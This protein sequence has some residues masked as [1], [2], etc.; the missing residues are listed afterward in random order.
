MGHEVTVV[1]SDRYYPFP[2]YQRTVFRL[3]GN[4]HVGAGRQSCDGFLIIRLKTRF[5]VRDKTWLRGLAATLDSLQPE[6]IICHGIVG[7][8]ALRLARLKKRLN[9][10]LVFDEHA[11]F[12]PLKLGIGGS[13]FY[14]FFDFKS[15][16]RSAD[17]LIAISSECMRVMVELY[18]FPED[19]VKLVPL[20]TDSDMFQ[21]NA[22][23]RGSFR[24]EHDISGDSI[25]VTYTGK[26]TF[27]K[28]PHNILLAAQRLSNELQKN[29]VL[30]FVG[31]PEERFVAMFNSLSKQVGKFVRVI[32]LPAVPNSQ[33]PRIY[34]GS[35]L[36]VWPRL[37]SIS[38]L[39]AASCGLPIICTTS[40]AERCKANNGIVVEDDNIEQ[41]TVAM[42]RLIQ[43]SDLRSAMGKRGRDLVERELSWRIIAQQ[44]LN[45]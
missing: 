36:A 38:T 7:F 12:S 37:P 34:C 18:G 5:E 4:R 42:S 29:L 32:Q 8:N 6:L 3:I 39:D 45:Y 25:V 21:F 15:I 14:R 30:L 13:L 44:F 22:D 10:R 40:V 41:L 16:R 9:C 43:D 24:K 31:D 28:G 19:T 26:L 33:L 27:L 35:D 23:K 1:A 20:G 2:D 11:L 17:A